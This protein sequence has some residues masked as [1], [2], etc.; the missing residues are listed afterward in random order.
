M[1][2]RQAGVRALRL[3]GSGATIVKNQ[4]NS[5]RRL[6]STG[7]GTILITTLVFVAMFVVIFSSLAGLVGRQY[8]ETV[9][10]AQDELA[11]QVAE[12]GLNYAR[13]R[14]AH[15]PD[16]YSAAHSPVSDQFAGTLGTYNV[17]F[18]EPVSGS[19]IVEIT[20]TGT[21]AARPE[22][23][24]TIAARYG[25][26]S[27]ARYAFITNSDV[28]YGGTISGI[29]HA[30]GGIRMDGQSDS[31]VQS[32]RAT[33][34]CQPIHGCNNEERP[35]VW[36]TGQLQ[37]L[38]EY[39]VSPIDYTALTVDLLTMKNEATSTNTY[40][41]SSG[42]FGYHLVFNDNNTYTMSR[43]TRK[44]GNVR[45]YDYDTGWINASHDISHETVIET[46]PV[47]SG[48]VI[49]AEDHLW[50]EGDIRDRV[51]VA[52]GRFPDTP[53]TNVDIILN[54]NIS[55]GGVHDGSRS[56]GAIAQ[57]HILI[58][59]FAAEDVLSIDGAFIAQKGKFGRRYYNSGEH[60]LKTRLNRFG[61]I[62]SNTPPGT[63]WVNS[64]GQITSGYQ[65]GV[66]TYD[67]NLLYGPP[68]YFPTSGQ[69]EFISWEEVQ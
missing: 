61:M 23:E 22:R 7:S 40:Y 66:A 64:Q 10:Q 46:K 59:Y 24:V 55:Y 43:V 19:T 65:E 5:F 1:L 51:T 49:Y 37:E 67:A 11:F 41:G 27:L 56:F 39:P 17:S 28:W 45:S 68:P 8:H 14:L 47:P 21:T 69:Y 30:N 58:P 29:V 34:R 32:A 20:A 31:L 35:G 57:R 26:P 25:I 3:G 13:W 38:W 63:A 4:M 62:G 33:Y 52:A 42:V 48:G 50:I 54:S 16:D 44:Q 12:A 36:G 15:A 2:A 53:A 18:T 6:N 9:L 60:R